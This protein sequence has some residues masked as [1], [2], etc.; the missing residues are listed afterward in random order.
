ME[1]KAKREH[2]IH[3]FGNLN[4]GPNGISP[5]GKLA[6]SRYKYIVHLHSYDG[7]TWRNM[8]NYYNGTGG[9]TK[10]IV[11]TSAITP[12]E[13][14]ANCV[15]EDVSTDAYYTCT[16]YDIGCDG[17]GYPYALALQSYNYDFA[18]VGEDNYYYKSNKAIG[19]FIYYYNGSA[20]TSKDVTSLFADENNTYSSASEIPIHPPRPLLTVYEN[21]VMDLMLWSTVEDEHV[22]DPIYGFRSNL[23]D[24]YSVI[25]SEGS[26]IYGQI[27]RIVTTD[28]DNFYE[29]CAVNDYYRFVS[30][31]NGANPT[32]ANIEVNANNALAPVKVVAKFWR[33][34]DGGD[35]WFR[36][37]EDFTNPFQKYA[38]SNPSNTSNSNY[39]DSGYLFTVLASGRR[40]AGG[41]A[42]DHS[43]FNF[44]IDKLQFD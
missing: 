22:H 17:N 40:K 41:G 11:S 29:G 27:Y 18:E 1:A 36:V 34:S 14:L 23:S 43:A 33:T 35:T 7:I 30:D 12:A 10:N 31:T 13:L 21:G 38:A 19:Y 9:F 4:E 20:W 24:P 6:N 42:L 2:G 5:D 15:V 16:L 28:T 25:E 39:K 26:L 8:A 44:F 37:R 3:L 32:P